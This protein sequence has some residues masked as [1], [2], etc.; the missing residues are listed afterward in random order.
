MA[1]MISTKEP[2]RRSEKIVFDALKDADHTRYWEV[3]YSIHIPD[4]PK[5]VRE[6]DFI[7]II[8]E[9]YSVICL[10]VK[11]GTFNI[12]ADGRW[13]THNGVLLNES[14]HD[15]VSHDMYALKNNFEDC[16]HFG[17]SGGGNKLSIGCA[18]AF[19]DMDEPTPPL[20][21]HLAK[22][23]WSSDVIDQNK[24]V[25][26]L[27]EIAKGISF[28]HTRYPNQ[29]KCAEENLKNLI[30]KLR[31]QD[32][33][34]QDPK[35]RSS[36]LDTLREKLLVLTSEQFHSL[37]LVKDNDCCIIDGAA[38][39]GKTVLAMEL[40][41][42]RCEENGEKVALICSN[43]YLSSRFVRWA[44]TL[45]DGNGGSVVAGTLEDFSTF[46]GSEQEKFDYL[47]VDEAQNLCDEKSQN[48][49]DRLL[50]KGLTN[51]NWA[52]FGDFTHQ[53]ITDPGLPKDGEKVLKHLQKLYPRMT[54]GRLKINCRNT[55]EIAAAV[56]MFLG[57]DSLPRSG[58]HGPL[59]QTKY[60]KKPEDL[61]GLLNNL[62]TD[63]KNREFYSRQIILLSSSS[64][65]FKTD[66]PLIYGGWRLFNVLEKEGSRELGQEDVP[67]V[68]GDSWD[69][70]PER[71]RYSDIHDFQGLESE[72][73][74][75]VIPLTEK[76][77]EVGDVATLPQYDYLQR[78]L[79]TGMSRAKAILVI[80]AH[81]SYEEHLELDP[82]FEPTYQEHIESI[83][84]DTQKS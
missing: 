5:P 36:D 69:S 11:G 57:I 28:Q 33:S 25:K 76:Q 6:I 16:F 68:S 29:E 27:K 10:E 60:F 46:G 62:V 58:V 63:F 61:D 78:V 71:L 15:K 52:M 49:M 4:P 17:G 2:S 51:G 84:Q 35:I 12:N 19:V 7:V 9:Y 67:D 75:L 23:I 41:K 45:S 26:K 66:P 50:K 80:V 39:T 8:P 73:V 47:I 20:L 13:S 38:G 59:I 55:Y 21:E 81:E 14:P 74:I 32:M 3:F 42:Q 31:P 37:D 48:L 56:S 22:S 24:L 44:N 77:T 53:N 43:P 34:I 65:D 64:D 30:V 79:Y 18:V 72:V 40:A 83:T 70:S 54:L 82:L 1:I